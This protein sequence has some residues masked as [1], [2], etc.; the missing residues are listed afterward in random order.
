[1]N[2]IPISKLPA[3]ENIYKSFAG[4]KIGRYIGS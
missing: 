3:D 4:T 2:G 1:M